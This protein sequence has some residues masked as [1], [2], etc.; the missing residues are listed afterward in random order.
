MGVYARAVEARTRAMYE[1]INGGDWHALVSASAPDVVHTF[2]GAHALGGRRTSREGLERWTGRFA[3]LYAGRRFEVREV[4]VRG[5]PLRTRVA[6]AWTAVL[7]PRGGEPY[8]NAGTHW[9]TLRRGRVV[10]LEEHLDTQAVAAALERMAAAG[11][12]EAGA[13]PI[14]D[15]QAEGAARGRPHHRLVRWLGHQPWFAVV[16]R[17]FAAPVD[18]VLYR[19]TGGRV[20]TTAGA[21][22]VLLLTTTGRRTG[23]PRTTPVMYARDGARYVVSSEHFG[24][25]RPAAWPRNLDADPRAVVQV[26][27]RTLPCRARRLEGAEADRAW[28]RLVELWPAHATYRA[29]SGQRHVFALEPRG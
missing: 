14:A 18:R 3:R 22:P 28:D 24:Q 26:G 9:I 16:G 10:G 27:R 20:G 25:E 5:G 4:A 2:P 8:A 1:Q 21:V 11:V 7:T 19:A 17:R 12:A 6:V 13:A 23:Q 29:R 15:Q